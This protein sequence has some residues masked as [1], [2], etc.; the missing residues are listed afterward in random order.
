MITRERLFQLLE[1]DSKAGKF[2]WLVDKG[3]GRAGQEAG[4]VRPD[5]YRDICLDQKH[6]LLHR[7]VWF[8]ETGSFP[9]KGLHLDHIDRDSTDSRIENLRLASVSQNLANSQMPCTNTSGAK[10]VSWNKSINKWTAQI[11]VMQKKIHLGCFVH[12]EDAAAA[13]AE[14]AKEHFGEFSRIV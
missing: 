9:P 2:Y 14:A 1:Y 4:H 11:H 5:G 13:Y 8:V 6:Y 7:L 12:I 3:K 10:G